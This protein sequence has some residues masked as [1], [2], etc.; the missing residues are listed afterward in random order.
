[1]DE[2]L[3]TEKL[4]FHGLQRVRRFLQLKNRN[5]SQNASNVTVTAKYVENGKN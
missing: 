3:K 5:A 2:V 1:M 4:N